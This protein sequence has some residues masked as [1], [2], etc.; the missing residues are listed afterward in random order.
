MKNFKNFITFLLIIIVTSCTPQTTNME[1][2]KNSLLDP[3][4][5]N[6]DGI[7]AEIKTNK[8]EINLVLEFQRAPL[9]VANFI[10]L[11]EG[12]I[13]NKIKDKNEPFYNGLK[14]H[15]VIKDF[16]IQG[17][18]PY[19]TGTGGPGYSFADEFHPDLKHSGP[20]I[21]SMANSGKN[22][23]GS[24]FFITHKETPWLDNKHSVFGHVLNESSQDIVNL[25]ETDDEIISVKIIR[26]GKL[27][28]KFDALDIFNV[29]KDE[30]EKKLV[31]EKKLAKEKFEK[32][33]TEIKNTYSNLI[34]TQSGLMYVILNEGNGVKPKK[35]ETVSVHY[36]G[37]LIDGTKFDSS[38]DRK[39]PIEFK[40]GIGQVIKGW[41]EGIEL[42]SIGGKAK[43]FIPP[44]L[45][46]G[47]RGAGGVIPPNATLIFD[48]ELIDIK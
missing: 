24:Q 18:C 25:I 45:A 26:N 4:S 32:Q 1:N 47:E 16:M 44:N 21:L 27:A 3:T 5:I 8:G 35:S 2:T 37:T 34:S 22:T 38:Y 11:S 13:K 15:R 39:T 23:N 36:T 48:V 40:L 7:F 33:I 17:G 14:F 46:Y 30:F 42:L 41:D 20:G 29:K 28:N 19:G 6:D 12:L 10:T 31:E 9:T 43:L